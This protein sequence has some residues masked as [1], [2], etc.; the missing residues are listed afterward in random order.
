MHS[1]HLSNVHPGWVAGGWLISIAV[2]SA[3]YLI[4]VSI[5]FASGAGDDSAW[6]VASV[7][8]GFFVGGFFVGVR[9]SEAPILHGLIFGLVSLV[10]VFALNLLFPETRATGTV[11]GDSV[12]LVLAML[13]IQTGAATVG[14][15]AGRRFFPTM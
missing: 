8:S 15:L 11:T 14:G 12:T 13:L 3:A 1:E 10:V 7:A 4:L 9:W 5:G 6:V 2:A